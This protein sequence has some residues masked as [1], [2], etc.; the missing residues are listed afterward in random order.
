MKLP[1]EPYNPKWKSSFE[2]I[3]SQLTA[4]LHPFNLSI[5][6]IGST[7]VE[8]LSAKPIIDILLGV[9]NKSDLD[10][11]ARALQ[12]PN[13]VYYEK[14]NEDMPGRRFFVLFNQSTREM[15]VA[16]VVKINEKIPE[17][18]H[19]HHLRIAHIHTFVKGSE[20]WMRHIAFRDYLSAYPEVKRE[21]QNL[22]QHLIQHEWNDG[23]EYNAAKDPFLKEQELI[24]LDW[25]KK[26]LENSV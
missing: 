2:Q 23:N 17:V 16:P 11:V 14:Y 10:E 20:D 8:G 24:A 18:L 25:Y 13:V 9:A 12:L 15:G 19:Q 21:Y 7:S 22:K 6:H 4:L 5:E 3:K 26:Q 1:F